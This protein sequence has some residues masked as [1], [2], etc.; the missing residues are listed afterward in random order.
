M[1]EIIKYTILYTYSK[2]AYNLIHITHCIIINL[3][4][5]HVKCEIFFGNFSHQY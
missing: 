5:F 4:Q 3:K 1:A 2:Q